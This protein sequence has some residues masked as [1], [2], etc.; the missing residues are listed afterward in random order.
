MCM[1]NIAF[2]S[3]HASYADLCAP[4]PTRLHKHIYECT[5]FYVCLLLWMYMFGHLY[6]HMT[7]HVV[8]R[9]LKSYAYV[10]WFSVSM[11]ISCKILCAE[12]QVCVY[13]M[14]IYYA[15]KPLSWPHMYPG[16]A[17][18]CQQAFHILPCLPCPALGNGAFPEN[19]HCKVTVDLIIFELF[20][21]SK[22]TMP[23]TAL[24]AP[25]PN[26]LHFLIIF[27]TY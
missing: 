12:P 20:L 8:I 22:N 21:I 24:L 17:P 26:L 2:E 10:A 25:I 27:F 3:A 11:F 4:I 6:L 7:S 14:R 9:S 13:A 18:G 19:F 1:C 5:C 16:W 23:E 15:S